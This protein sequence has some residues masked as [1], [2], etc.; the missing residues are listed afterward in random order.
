MK[1]FHIKNVAYPPY[2]RH[3][4]W[5]LDPAPPPSRDHGDLTSPAPSRDHGIPTSGKE[6]TPPQ[7]APQSAPRKLPR[8]IRPRRRKERQSGST[9]NHNSPSWKAG[10]AT[11]CEP[12]ANQNSPSREAGREQQPRSTTNH[13]SP[14]REA[15]N[16]PGMNRSTGS[17]MRTPVEHPLTFLHP[18]HPRLTA[19]QN[20]ERRFDPDHSES[21][22]LFKPVKSSIQ[23]D[24]ALRSRRDSFSGSGLSSPALQRSHRDSFSGSP[25]GH[26]SGNISLTDPKREERIAG[27]LRSGLVLPHP[28]AACPDTRIELDAALPEAAAVSR[29][30]RPPTRGSSPKL[31][32]RSSPRRHSRKRPRNRSSALYRPKKRPPHPSHWCE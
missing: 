28:R 9:A 17:A 21:G 2:N 25:V 29:A 8:K 22:C 30:E 11:Q 3:L 18:Q 5:I 10:R 19:N 4:N 6:N 16:Q 26:L 32:A 20:S 7:S 15:G 13:N 24:S 27:G 14:S 31:E 23:Q 1:K 12:A